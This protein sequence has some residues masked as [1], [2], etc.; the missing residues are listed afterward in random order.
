MHGATRHSPADKR[1]SP[2]RPSASGYRDGVARVAAV[3]AGLGGL[4]TAARL[5][6]T[7]HSVTVLDQADQVGEELGWYFRDGH[8]FDPGPSLVTWPQVYRELFAATGGRL[9]DA[10]DLVRLDPAVAYRFPDGTRLMM[11]GT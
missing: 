10:V 2:V 4:A 6:S 1:F 5:A 7:G 11:P 8:A 9:E 3:G